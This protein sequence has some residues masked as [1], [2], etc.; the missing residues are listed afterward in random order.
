MNQIVENL[1]KYVIGWQ[2]TCG[3]CDGYGEGSVHGRIETCRDRVSHGLPSL[4]GDR[5]APAWPRFPGLRAIAMSSTWCS[6]MP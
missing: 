5:R 6:T 3:F 1:N 2:Y 4:N